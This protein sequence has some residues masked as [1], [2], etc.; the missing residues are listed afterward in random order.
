MARQEIRGNQGPILKWETPGQKIEG[1]YVR[2]RDGKKFANN[3]EK[4]KLLDLRQ[5]DGTQISTGA[6]T[7]LAGKMA[8]VV[9]GAYVWIEYLGKERSKAGNE[10]KN[11]KVEADLEYS[12]GQGARTLAPPIG[13]SLAAM[14]SRLTKAKGA[15][16]AG[17][18][19]D[20]LKAK[21]PDA[22]AY[23]KALGDV[24]KSNGIIV[25][26]GDSEVPF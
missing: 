14:E 24:L 11:F 16:V 21:Y 8:D 26:A 17:L 6:P 7:A 9:I 25:S 10:F 22:A 4:S 1:V 23:E 18:M 20:A 19:I 2:L 15:Q 12:Q 5:R 13:G 3:A